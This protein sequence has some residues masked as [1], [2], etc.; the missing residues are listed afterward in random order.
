MKTEDARKFLTALSLIMKVEQAL[1][2]DGYN[3]YPIS[4]FVNRAALENLTKLEFSQ[5]IRRT[6]EEKLEYKFETELDLY[7]DVIRNFGRWIKDE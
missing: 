5:L 3:L 7:D 1:N 6:L 2:L 4:I